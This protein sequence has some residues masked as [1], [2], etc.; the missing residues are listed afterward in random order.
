MGAGLQAS[1]AGTWIVGSDNAHGKAAAET[2]A[3]DNRAHVRRNNISIVS[4][5][6]GRN[7]RVVDFQ[8]M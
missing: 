5:D 3:D 1:T 7:T 8:K 2:K 4:S 6:G